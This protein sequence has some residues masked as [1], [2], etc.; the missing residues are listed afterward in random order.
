VGL[1]YFGGLTAEET[2]EALGGPQS[3]YKETGQLP[4]RGFTANLPVDPPLH[5]VRQNWL[6][7]PQLFPRQNN[8]PGAEYT[9]PSAIVARMRKFSIPMIDFFSICRYLRCAGSQSPR[10]LQA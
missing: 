7:S 10:T 3:P 8:L 5:D 2:G 6:G 4:K 1:R 9:S